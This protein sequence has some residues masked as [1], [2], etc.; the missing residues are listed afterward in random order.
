LS[1]QELYRQGTISLHKGNAQEAIA[2]LE[3]A[4]ALRGDS[5]DAALNLSGA[6]ILSGQFR[7][8]LPI[9]EKLRDLD[10]A[11]EMVWTNLGAAHLGNPILSTGEMQEKS[12]AAFNRALEINP[13]APNVA[14]NL[15]LIHRDRKE[16]AES[17]SWFERQL[18][19][20]PTDKHAASMLDKVRKLHS[21]Q[22]A[23]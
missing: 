9:L 5:K 12:I 10:P 23:R 18:E 6:Y 19:N 17:I 7:K 20:Y 21:G 2:P 3:Q 13:D 22:S 8:A 11:N 1:F 14:Y 16:Y 4:L 15:G